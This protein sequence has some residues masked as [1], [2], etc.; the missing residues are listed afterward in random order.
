MWLH[1][2]GQLVKLL[3]QQPHV[4]LMA[5]KPV[6]PS[7]CSL[8]LPSDVNAILQ[9]QWMAKCRRIRRSACHCLGFVAIFFF[10][11]RLSMTTKKI[12]E[13]V[14]FGENNGVTILSTFSSEVP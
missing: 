9:W 11:V 6:H 12:E 1:N 2:A 8:T 4:T 3:A 14:N 13:G 10:D 7:R 5:F